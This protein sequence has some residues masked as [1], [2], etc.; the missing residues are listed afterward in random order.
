MLTMKTTIDSAG[1]IVI[2]RDLRRAAGLEAGAPVEISERD[3]VI[4]IEP[5][6]IEIRMERRGRLMVAVPV[7][8]VPKIT[9]AEVNAVRDRIR[10][11]R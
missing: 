2:P 10:E 3:G 6:P 5:A 8:P 11:R 9:T 7:K 4:T 1:R